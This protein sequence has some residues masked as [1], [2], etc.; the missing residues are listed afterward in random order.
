MSCNVCLP[1]LHNQKPETWGQTKPG[2][3]RETWETRGQKPGDRRKVPATLSRKPFPFIQTARLAVP[4][5]PTL[6]SGLT[7]PKRMGVPGPALSRRVSPLR[8]GRRR[9]PMCGFS[10]T[11]GRPAPGAHPFRVLCATGGKPRPARHF[12]SRSEAGGF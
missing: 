6:A 1:R 4:P 12:W 5:S 7:Q 8:P 2:D 3:R 9:T 11:A 10:L